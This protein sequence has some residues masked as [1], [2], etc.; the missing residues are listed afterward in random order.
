MPELVHFESNSPLGVRLGFIASLI[1]EDGDLWDIGCDH[2]LILEWAVRSHRISQIVGVDRSIHVIRKLKDNPLFKDQSSVRFICDLGQRLNWEKI[3]G[4]VVI[5]GMGWPNARK[6][7]EKA[8][9]RKGP[10][11]WILAPHADHQ[12][13][14]REIEEFSDL[15]VWKSYLLRDRQEEYL[16]LHG[17]EP[18]GQQ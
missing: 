3:S 17:R 7:L 11:N 9:E 10:R 1:R 16:I 13:V 4:N 15:G 6:I 12:T 18:K 5:A 2:G 8:Q 14:L